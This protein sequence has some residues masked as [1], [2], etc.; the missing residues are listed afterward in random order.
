MT[1]PLLSNQIVSLSNSRLK[2]A[3]DY[4]QISELKPF[5]KNARDHSPRQI[6]QLTRSIKKFGFVV[7]ILVDASLNIIAGH[8]RLLAAERLGLAEVP[9]ILLD[10]LTEP[11]VRT[12]AIADNR[13]TE[14]SRW[15]DQLLAEQL[16]ELSLLGLDFSLEVTGFEM[17]EIDLRI[18]GLA[19]KPDS[20]SD[21]AD[22]IPTDISR[23]SVS[24]PG[25]LYLL[26]RHRVFC[27]SALDPCSFTSLMDGERA[28]MVFTDPPYNVRIVGH[29]SGLGATHHREFPMASGEMD[30]QQFTD[31]LAGACSLMASHSVDGSI[32]FI[33]MDWRHCNE[34]SAAALL[35]Y[36]EHKNTCVWVKTN[37]GMGSLYR[38]QHE[39][40]FVY[41]NGKSPHR[42]NIELGKFGRHRSNVWNYPGINSFGRSGEEGN[43]LAVHP[44]V[45][46]VALVADA[47]LDCSARGDLVLDPFLGSGTTI[48]AAERTG[49][50]C[51]GIE[52]DPL[53]VDTIIRRWQAFTGGV[54]LHAVTGDTFNSRDVEARHGK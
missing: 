40:I 2:F 18:E 44:T 26:D 8:G 48:I 13:I 3:I 7:P 32:H 46:P 31:F 27:G 49:R 6:R 15:N 47:I 19:A 35:M 16:N 34:L 25:D 9:V 11:E 50:R 42:N 23:P 45:K 10:Y 36:S 4:R 41:K 22:T 39:F 28:S 53:Y 52:I 5:T 54:A 38:S 21:P 51:Y 24:Q 17:A 12:L 1:T 37:A 43:L 29:A 14:N 20:Q 30:P 33:C